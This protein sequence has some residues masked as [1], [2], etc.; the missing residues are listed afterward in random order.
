MND[1]IATKLAKMI[2]VIEWADEMRSNEI[3]I[4]IDTIFYD[5]E[6]K[7]EVFASLNGCIKH[8]QAVAG[9]ELEARLD[10]MHEYEATYGERA[11]REN[12]LRGLAG[13][14]GCTYEELE[15]R[16]V[17]ADNSDEQNYSALLAWANYERGMGQERIDQAA[18]IAKYAGA[19]LS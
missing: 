8:L 18:K 11:K 16:D 5:G 13:K 12:V 14:I 15:A 10:L 1:R 19:V 6:T 7:T 17:H 3:S 9:D 4:D 2:Q